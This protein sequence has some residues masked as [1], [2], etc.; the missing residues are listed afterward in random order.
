M[1]IQSRVG[2]DY[3]TFDI[4]G[5]LD[6]VS[7]SQAEAALNDAIEAGASRLVVNLAGLE[8]V[9]SA[10]LRVVLATAKRLSRRDGKMVLCELQSGVREVF[11]MSGLLSILSVAESEA[12]AHSLVTA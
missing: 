3:T 10:G 7:A 4:R 9:S 11:S 5:R 6:A 12:T 1:E 2:D 8:Y